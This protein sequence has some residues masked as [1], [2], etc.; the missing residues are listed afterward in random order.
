MTEQTETVEIGG[1][2]AQEPRED[3][4]GV[5]LWNGPAAS[6]ARYGE[7]KVVHARAKQLFVTDTRKVKL[8]MAECTL[9]AAA[10]LYY[11]ADSFLGE[12]VA[13]ADNRDGERKFTMMRGRPLVLR[14]SE[15]NAR[16]VGTYLEPA[17]YRLITDET[18]RANLHIPNEALAF[19][20]TVSDYRSKQDYYNRRLIYKEEGRKADEIDAILG[21]EPAWVGVGIL[22]KPEMQTLD[23]SKNKMT[24]VER[25]QKRAL[26][27][28]LRK[29]WLFAG[30][31]TVRDF[32]AQARQL[33]VSKFVVD[34]EWRE[35][36]ED[37][38]RL[39]SPSQQRQ[40]TAVRA[41]RASSSLYGDSPRPWKPAAVKAALQD[42]TAKHEKANHSA[43]DKQRGLMVGL[44]DAICHGE[45]E[46]HSWLRWA[47]GVTSVKDTTGPQI[48][49][50]LDYLKPEEIV[51]ELAG[52][53]AKKIVACKAAYPEAA[54]IL[55]EILVEAGQM[56]LGIGGE[57]AA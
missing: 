21:P 28:A 37:R 29:H 12:I 7:A 11:D 38:Q 42:A 16:A 49:A 2:P 18:E 56:D 34:G 5:I 4:R 15:M 40:E 52:N 57:A 8:T 17:R 3:E 53:G 41:A 1:G 54:A 35:A 20:A 25:C 50:V 30:R 22:T 39:G 45:N 33:D 23:A 6:L 27:A 10:E 46:R 26:T 44:L 31:G 48:L 43:T 36:I 14:A 32:E 47:F 55:K 24:H 19:E 13:W 9:M 51:D